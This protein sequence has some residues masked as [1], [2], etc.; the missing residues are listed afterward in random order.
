M[1]VP[2]NISPEER[3]LGLVV[4]LVST[5]NGLSKE[6]ILQTVAG[7]REG[8]AS[9]DAQWR[10]FDRDKETLRAMGVPIQ[11]IGDPSDADDLREARY[12]VPE[13]EYALP[14]DITFDDAELAVLQVAGRAWEA[15]SL[16]D[17][18]RDALRKIGALGHTVETSLIGFAPQIAVQEAAFV[19]LQRAIEAHALVRFDYVNAG[20]AE[21]RARQVAPLALVQFEGRWHLYAIDSRVDEPR[22]FLLSRI[23]GEVRA[24]REQF[25]PGLAEGAGE[26]ALAGLAAHAEA[27]LALL[28]ITPG[29]EAALRVGRRGRPDATQGVRVPFV[30]LEIF[31]AELA[32]YGPEV[33]VVEPV[34][35]RDAVIARLQAAVHAHR[36]HGFRAS[37]VP[38]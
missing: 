28:E 24:T 33:R 31:A 9:R 12:R 16:S 10:M 35:L 23:R 30:D 6:T 20:S 7:Y 5:R 18:A 29:T 25:E 1:H 11:T 34:A 8:G 19:P 36:D 15:S 2:A 4:A 3:L 14:A 32:S 17:A 22:T 37:E 38:A 27:N 26:R 21:V 13:S